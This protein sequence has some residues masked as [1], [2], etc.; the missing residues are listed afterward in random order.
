MIDLLVQCLAL[1]RLLRLC[2][3]DEGPYGVLERFRR[4]IGIDERGNYS[5]E[6]GGLFS[7][8]RCL[9]IW[10]VPAIVFLYM[11]PYT[12]WIAWCLAVAQ[13]ANLV[14]ALFNKLEY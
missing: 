6:L 5:N 2:T 8:Y 10:L 3:E 12:Y 14:Y 13:G 11:N 9:G 1:A 7:C 4:H